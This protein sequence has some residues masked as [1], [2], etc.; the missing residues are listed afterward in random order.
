MHGAV[1]RPPTT[2]V[3]YSIRA[4]LL[5][6]RT[7]LSGCATKEMPC[8]SITAAGWVISSD[9]RCRTKEMPCE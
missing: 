2:I 5:L 6:G 8:Q 4:R 1:G 7:V 9:G 3:V